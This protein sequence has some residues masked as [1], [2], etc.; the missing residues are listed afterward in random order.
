MGK[1][2]AAVSASIPPWN[3]GIDQVHDFGSIRPKI[4]LI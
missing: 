2:G 1:S 4:I 3:I